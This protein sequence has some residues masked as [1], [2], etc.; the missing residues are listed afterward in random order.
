MLQKRETNRKQIKVGEHV[1][2]KIES[3]KYLGETVNEKI[4]ELQKLCN[5]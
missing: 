4:T 3:F 1:N 2:V 5:F